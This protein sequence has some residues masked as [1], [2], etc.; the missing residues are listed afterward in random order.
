MIDPL[1]WVALGLAIVSPVGLLLS[2]DWRWQI[3][4]LAGQYLAAFLMIQTHW[5]V[6][7]AASKL[8]TG[9]MACAILGIA[10]LNRARKVE[11]DLPYI[12]GRLFSIF[13]AFIVLAVSFAVSIQVTDWLDLPLPIAWGSLLLVALGLLQLGV[14]SDPFRVIIGLLSI[15]SGFEILYST[16]ERSILVTALLAVVNLGLALVGAYFLVPAEE[17]TA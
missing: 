11:R 8:V 16:V 9:W 12:Q 2:R 6:S 1:S 5:P 17:E 4:F 13:T 3:G 7:M 15:L 14:T 10:Q